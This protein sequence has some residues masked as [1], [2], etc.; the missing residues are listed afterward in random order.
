MR[1]YVSAYMQGIV[2]RL[3]SQ[4]QWSIPHDTPDTPDLRQSD[5]TDMNEAG[6]WCSPDKRMVL[7]RWS[8]DSSFPY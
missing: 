7:T 3:L 1:G 4:S 2:S 8:R 5:D 6:K